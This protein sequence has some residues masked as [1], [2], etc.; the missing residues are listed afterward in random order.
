MTIRFAHTLEGGKFPM[1]PPKID[2]DFSWPTQYGE[3]GRTIKYYR[4]ALSRP[5]PRCSYNEL[6]CGR[7]TVGTPIT[8]A[9][10][11]APLEECSASSVSIACS[12]CF[13]GCQSLLWV[14][15]PRVLT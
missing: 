12:R 15:E 4:F 1:R 3:S 2:L 6:P 10:S 7:Y 9:T 14:G 13:V 5:P 8:A 11:T